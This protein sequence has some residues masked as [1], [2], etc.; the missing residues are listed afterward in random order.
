MK[1]I[2]MSFLALFIFPT[3]IRA[4]AADFKSF[5][6]TYR[7]I[8]RSDASPVGYGEVEMVIDSAGLKIRIATGS[9]IDVQERPAAE[10]IALGLVQTAALFKPGSEYLKRFT[11]FSSARNRW[12]MKMLFMSDARFEKN[13]FAVILRHDFFDTMLLG[14]AQVARGDFERLL[15]AADDN[16]GK[17]RLPRL[18]VMAPARHSKT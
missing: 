14:P 3:A 12:P 5:V 11:A 8:M 4:D 16:L 1:L 10:F 7:G 15:K 2:R 13:E 17:G 9:R 18:K 6:G